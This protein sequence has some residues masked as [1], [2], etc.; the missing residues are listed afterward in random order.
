MKKMLMS[1]SIV[2]LCTSVGMA[3]YQVD[4]TGYDGDFFSLEGAIEL[5]RDSRSLSQ[6]ERRLNSRK[7]YVNN[8]DLDYDGRTDYIRVDHYSEGDFHAVIMQVALGRREMQ[9]VAVIE[10]EKVGPRDAVLQIVGDGYL[11]GEE[12]VVEPYDDYEYSRRRGSDDYVNVYYWPIVQNFYHRDYVAYRSP[13]RWDYYPTWWVT[14]RPVTWN[15][16][17]T[18][19]RPF[20]RRC[21]VINV[22]RIPRVHTFY[23]PYRRYSPVIADRCVVLRD[24][25]VVGRAYGTVDRRPRGLNTA[26]IRRSTSSRGVGSTISRTSATRSDVT[27]RAVRS[28]NT[29]SSRSPERTVDRRRAPERVSPNTRFSARAANK[30]VA[31]SERRA[32]NRSEVGRPIDR[33]SSKVVTPRSSSKQVKRNPAPQR[34]SEVQRPAPRSNSKVVAPRRSSSEARRP[35]PRVKS[36]PRPAPN[37]T[38]SKPAPRSKPSSVKRSSAPSRKVSKPAPSRTP[39]KRSAPSR[40]RKN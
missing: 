37:R 17:L 15:I 40:S 12:V 21:R 16:Y 31:P 19:I 35:A 20:R 39:S 3:Q 22:Y 23:A 1:M 13:Y 6:F 8:L 7:N 32:P 5:F 10:I 33:S 11:Y 2:A 36:Q 18:N 4:R 24:R 30:K 28:P 25:G 26:T 9:D 27:R 38:Y 29:Q 14:W 34:R